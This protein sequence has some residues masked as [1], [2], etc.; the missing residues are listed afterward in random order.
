MNTRSVHHCAAT[1]F[2]LCSESKPVVTSQFIQK[3]PNLWRF[4]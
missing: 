1:V 3:S 4:V 2:L